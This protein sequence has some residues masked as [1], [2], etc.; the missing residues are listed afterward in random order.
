[1]DFVC[2]EFCNLVIAKLGFFLLS[3]EHNEKAYSVS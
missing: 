1:M 3:F 2:S